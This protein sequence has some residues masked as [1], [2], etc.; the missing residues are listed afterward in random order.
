MSRRQRAYVMFFLWNVVIVG[1]FSL[2]TRQEYYTI[3]AIPGMALLVGGWLQRERA[4]AADSRERRSGRISSAVLLAVGGLF[5]T[6]WF[7]LL[8]FSMAPPPRPALSDP[9]RKKSP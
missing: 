3:P 5:S 2:S 4:P 7:A 9:F 6:G 8:L 1:F